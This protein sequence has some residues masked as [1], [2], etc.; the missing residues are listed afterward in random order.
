[1]KPAPT[2]TPVVVRSVVRTLSRFGAAVHPPVLVVADEAATR[3]EEILGDEAGLLT[4]GP[5]A[6]VG[7]PIQGAATGV[8]EV[9]RHLRREDVVG[10]EVTHGVVPA[11]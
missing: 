5:F 6:T 1:M 9:S 8:E 11:P 7:Q 10:G 2:D 3:S 4:A